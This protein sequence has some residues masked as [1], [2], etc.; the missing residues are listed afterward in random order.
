MTKELEYLS[1]RVATGKMNAVTS[2]VV[3]PRSV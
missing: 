1:H 2:W 3:P